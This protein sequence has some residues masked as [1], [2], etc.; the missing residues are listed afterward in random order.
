MELDDLRTTV[1]RRL[2]AAAADGTLDHGIAM[3]RISRAERAGSADE[4]DVLLPGLARPGPAAR[5]HFTL[6]VE[7]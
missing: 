6:L 4:L 5:P 7:E 2:H 1:L 3:S